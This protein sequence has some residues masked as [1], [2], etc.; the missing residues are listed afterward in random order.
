MINL[1]C[2]ITQHNQHV[3]EG[4]NKT[5]PRARISK[6]VEKRTHS[7]NATA[8]VKKGTFSLMNDVQSKGPKGPRNLTITCEIMLF[9][10]NKYR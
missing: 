5:Y 7:A 8:K 9:I 1:V 2:K 10:I 4:P 6:V 3:S